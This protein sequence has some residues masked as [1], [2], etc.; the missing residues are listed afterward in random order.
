MARVSVIEAFSPAVFEARLLEARWRAEL[1]DLS[2]ASVALGLLADAVESALFVL[3]GDR[4]LAQGPQPHLWGEADDAH[5]MDRDDARV[6]I[7]MLL[8]EGAGI[9]EL[10]RGDKLAARQLLALALRLAPRK[11]DLKRDFRRI[12]ADVDV[13]ESDVASTLQRQPSTHQEGALARADEAVS[14]DPAVGRDQAP[15]VTPV[16]VRPVTTSAPPI[17]PFIVRDPLEV[18]L[19]SDAPMPDVNDELLVEQLSEQLRANPSDQTIARELV[20][21]LDGL[22]RNHEL[23]ALLSAL[24]DESEGDARKAWLERRKLVLERMIDRATDEG[25][26]DEAQLYALMLQRN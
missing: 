22:R 26:L 21:L 25:R 24:V 6:A 1:G 18:T 2:G 16:A 7:G 17:G 9:H 12:A 23:L 15:L 11:H 13:A 19:D 14:T 20:E 4:P 3:V 10:D 5:Y 8:H